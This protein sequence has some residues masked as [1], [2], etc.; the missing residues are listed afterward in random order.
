MKAKKSN[1]NK[2]KGKDAK[3]VKGI[4]YDDM[5]NAVK[6]AAKTVYRGAKRS[7]RAIQRG[8]DKAPAV[9]MDAAMGAV[10]GYGNLGKQVYQTGKLLATGDKEKYGLEANESYKAEQAKV[11]ANKEKA[12]AEGK[13][14][15]E[16]VEKE[17]A[18][19]KRFK[20]GGKMSMY[21]GGGKMYGKK[22]MRVK[23]YQEGGP[24]VPDNKG[25][26]AEDQAMA[27]VK[28]KGA[29]RR[30]AL[31]PFYDLESEVNA[32]RKTYDE[33]VERLKV[34]SKHG[35]S[36]KRMLQTLR[37]DREAIASLLKDDRMNIE[38]VS[39]VERSNLMR[40]MPK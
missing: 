30:A 31:Q 28:Q 33:H 21:A 37:K 39:G 13:A 12:E 38:G 19:N 1:G 11:E 14:Y 17:R 36:Y 18:K 22:G 9:M 34:L 32:A 23:K 15:R 40:M 5:G 29:E 4:T 16:K 35:P 2:S 10:E 6:D 27:I 24:I 3:V 8:L 26:T 25:E 7:A 20:G